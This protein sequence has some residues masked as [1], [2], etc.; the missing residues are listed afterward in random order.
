MGIIRWQSKITF[1]KQKIDFKSITNLGVDYYEI[2][3]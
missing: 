2:F 3:G 1:Y